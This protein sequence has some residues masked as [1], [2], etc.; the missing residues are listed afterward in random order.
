MLASLLGA[1]GCLPPPRAANGQSG[2]LVLEECTL[3]TR[4]SQIRA[5]CGSLLV[6]EDPTAASGRQIALNVTVIRSVSREP[7]PDPLFLLAGGPGQAATEAFLPFIDGL[8]RVRFK[9]D[10]VLVDQR[11]TGQSNPLDCSYEQQTPEIY[12]ISLPDDEQAAHLRACRARIDADPR[13]Y[14]T[15]IAMHDLDQVRDSLGYEQVNLLGVSY[16]TRAALTYLRLYPERVRTL[17]LDGVVPPNWVLGSAIPADA[18]RALDMIFARCAADEACRAA[19][20]AL[21]EDFSALRASLEAEPVE[22]RMVHPVSGR[23]VRVQMN[24]EVLSSTVRMITYSDLLVALLPMGIDSA[25]AGD[26]TLLAGLYLQIVE[27]LGE[28]MSIGMH[29]SVVCVEDMPLLRDKTIQE[30]SYLISTVPDLLAA[31]EIW[32]PGA[33][34]PP[35]IHPQTWDTPALLISGE[36]DPVTPPGN[37]EQMASWLPNSLHLVLLGMGHNNFYA[38]CV[39]EL[40]LRFLE[41]ASV[42][43]LNPACIQN[44]QPMPFFVSPAGPQP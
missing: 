43:G 38:G 41:T 22:L 20:P 9:R 30:D 12:G 31:C 16:G 25:A 17:V 44:I 34:P 23:P 37:G 42:A 21:A 27:D 4:Q 1:S 3:S 39:P 8:E 29:H 35:P 33:P 32:L 24:A 19:Y 7:A 5:E 15:E 13:L 40:I 14:A 28:S 2:G 11:G 10:L 26:Y 36:A 18:Q 6:D